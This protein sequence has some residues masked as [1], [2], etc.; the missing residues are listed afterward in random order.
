MT[1][2]ER[3]ANHAAEIGGLLATRP[4]VRAINFHNTSRA[5]VGVIEKQLDLC[6]QHF[7]SVNEDDLDRI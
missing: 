7:S 6:S 5:S 4:L 3:F 2:A 1:S